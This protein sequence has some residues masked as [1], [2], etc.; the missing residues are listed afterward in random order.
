VGACERML[1]YL[2]SKTWTSGSASAAF[3]HEVERA[4]ATGVPLLLCHEMPGV[5]GQAERHGVAFDAFF[6]C[7]HGTTPKELL[8][9]NIYSQI[10]TALK[11]GPWRDVS[12]V[13]VAQGLAAEPVTNGGE[14]GSSGGGQRTHLKLLASATSLR[15]TPR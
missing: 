10:A 8:Q 7:A 11:G 13:L 9:Q 12:M 2:T 15:K 5:G 4:L 14:D 1:V 6:S 3:A